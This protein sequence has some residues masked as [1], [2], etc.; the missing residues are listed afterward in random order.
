MQNM[1]EQWADIPGYED[2]YQASNLG[3]IR[4]L[5]C[6]RTVVRGWKISSK[7]IKGEI[8]A[9][10][11]GMHNTYYVV[12]LKIEKGKSKTEL[13]HRL[14]A[15]AFLNPAHKL[16]T[17]VNHIDGNKLNNSVENLEWV[18]PSENVQ[19]ALHTGLRKTKYNSIPI[20]DDPKKWRTVYDN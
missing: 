12:T 5:D 2:Y 20:V 10:R 17:Q 11:I 16:Q 14:V 9:Q 7:K 3:R 13:V 6:I 18:T 19:H 1:C 8:I 4:S 15:L